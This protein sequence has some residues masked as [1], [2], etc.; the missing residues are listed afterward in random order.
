[1][2]LTTS[3]MQIFYTLDVYEVTTLQI[4]CKWPYQRQKCKYFTNFRRSW[5]PH[6]ANNLQMTLPTSKMQ[7]FY[8]LDVHEVTTLQII[9]K[10][11]CQSQKCKD[12]KIYLLLQFPFLI[13]NII[14][15]CSDFQERNGFIN[16]IN[17][18]MCWLQNCSTNTVV[19]RSMS[20]ADLAPAFI[21]L[22][23]SKAQLSKKLWRKGTL[24]KSVIWTRKIWSKVLL[25]FWEWVKHYCLNS[26]K[27]S[28]RNNYIKNFEN[29]HILTNF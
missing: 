4:I 10:W 18:A 16:N 7:I 3:K 9:C 2:A 17:Q 12:F 20:S 14:R 5:G 28:N 11:P 15:F 22:I 25:N 23:L 6:I 1:M 19:V 8:T 24:S 29:F 13:L 27:K 26:L 21:L